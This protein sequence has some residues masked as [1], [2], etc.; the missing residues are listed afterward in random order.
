MHTHQIIHFMYSVH[1][2]SVIPSQREHRMNTGKKR[3]L[4][5]AV[6]VLVLSMLALPVAAVIMTELLNTNLDGGDYQT[7]A[8]PAKED[9]SS[10]CLNDPNCL[11][12]TWVHRVSSEPSCW[13]KN[14]VPPSTPFPGG[15]TLVMHSYIKEFPPPVGSGC[16]GIAPKVS[17][18]VNPTSGTAPLTI[19]FSNISQ[20]PHGT[21]ITNDPGST[22]PA[23]GGMSLS[24]GISYYT[25]SAPGT[26]QWSTT[27]TDTCGRSDTKITTITVLPPP[28]PPAGSSCSGITPRADFS[29]S[30]ISGTAP[31]TVTFTDTS[32]GVT[33]TACYKCDM[34]WRSGDADPKYVTTSPP[35]LSFTRTFTVPGTYTEILRI[36]CSEI[37][38]SRKINDT[39][40]VTITVFSP[41]QTTVPAPAASTPQQ[42]GPALA[43]TQTTLIIISV[44][45]GAAVFVDMTARGITPLQLTAVDPGLHTVLLKKEGY[46]DYTTTATVIAGKVTTLNADLIKG[47][48]LSGTS[49]TTATTRP[50]SVPDNEGALSVTTNSTEMTKTTRVSQQTA[51]IA[52]VAA[53]IIGIVAAVVYLRKKKPE[54]K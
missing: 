49:A 32:P 18:D 41:S 22:N 35:G 1:L 44:P 50:P 11:A 54:N 51:L 20:V 27:H 3:T 30:P 12:A 24:T 42:T 36:G 43:G 45:E 10:A 29:A 48:Q 8:A 52:M 16:S 40:T 7:I 53:I 5:L 46:P 31:L 19:V 6:I 28:P 14:T 2:E 25:Y 34:A 39:K 17:Y 38:G 9:C 15:M 47:P 33:N 13:L 4:M 23:D 37:G 21:T 26:Y